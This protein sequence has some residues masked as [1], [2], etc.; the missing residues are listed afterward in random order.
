MGC[1]YPHH[2]N[3]LSLKEAIACSPLVAMHPT[4][5]AAAPQ[6][7]LLRLHADCAELA[8][9]AAAAAAANAAGVNSIMGGDV[10]GSG[11]LRSSGT[12]AG[13][14]NSSKAGAGSGQPNAPSPSPAIMQLVRKLAACSKPPAGAG[15]ASSSP[16]GGSGMSPGGGP[17]A[18]PTQILYVPADDLARWLV[19]ASSSL[20]AE[21]RAAASAAVTA[22]AWERAGLAKLADELE[23]QVRL[24]S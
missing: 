13:G 2:I 23:A 3:S 24:T 20:A 1:Y 16:S 12:W 18:P 22:A 11:A 17:G 5:P 10:R 6:V 21:G 14:P 15:G 9:L 7:A 4:R 19:E 8:G